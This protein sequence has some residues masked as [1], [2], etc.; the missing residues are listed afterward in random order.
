MAIDDLLRLVEHRL[1]VYNRHY[2]FDFYGVK[3]KNMKSRTVGSIDN[4][5]DLIYNA[6]IVT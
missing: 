5:H 1:D 4:Q 3:I 6:P 2:R